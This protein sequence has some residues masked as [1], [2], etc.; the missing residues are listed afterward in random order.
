MFGNST[1]S[2]N[3]VDDIYASQAD[4]GNNAFQNPVNPANMNPG[5]GIDP[6]LLSPSYSANYRPQYSG[7]N[8]YNSYGHVGFFKGLSNLSPTSDDPNWGNPFM[9]QRQSI[10]DV[11]NR[12]ADAA[13]WGIQRI[14][15]PALAF[16]G[17]RYATKALGLGWGAGSRFGAGLGGGMAQ[18]FGFKPA[19]TGGLRA[20]ASAVSAAFSEGGIGAGLSTLRGVGF[21]GAMNLAARGGMG[22]AMGAAASLAMPLVI[23]QGG[24]YAAE[25]TLFDP[26]INTRKG[27]ENLR[28]NFDGISFSDST[29]NAITGKGL[30][31]KEST[32]M[33]QDLTHQGIDDM[34]FSTGEYRQGADMISRSGLLDSTNSKGLSKA[35]K[36]SMEQIKLIMNIA[37]M[38][39]LKDAIEELAKL[40]MAGASI[41]GGVASN[42]SNTMRTLGGLAAAAGTTVSKLMNTV[43]A[44][45][46]YLYQANGMTPYLGQMAA[47]GSYSAFA[48]GKRTGIIST[49][50]IARMGGLEGATQAS[51]TGQ[52]NA[53][54]TLFNQMA[55]YNS[56]IKGKKG[57]SGAG[58]Q[59]DL[60]QVTGEFGRSI[61]N[62]PLGTYGGLMLHG[63]QM[64]GK[65]MEERGS[66]AVQDQ[67]MPIA[68]QLGLIDKKTGKI[69]AERATPI[70]M[71]MGM[72]KDQIQ[73]YYEQ[74][75][76]ESDPETLKQRRKGLAANYKEQSAQYISQNG[77]YGGPIGSSVYDVRKA[78]RQVTNAVSDNV[79][80]PVTSAVGKFG[81]WVQETVHEVTYNNTL[82]TEDTNAEKY[83]GIKDSNKSDKVAYA[84]T[85]KSLSLFE[86]KTNSVNSDN[87]EVT[88]KLNEL[89]KA[90][91]PKVVEYF[92]T[93]DT[94]KRSALIKNL[95]N[96]GVLGESIKK[97]YSA[98]TP[99]FETPEFL[100][101]ATELAT[102]GNAQ[103]KEFVTEKNVAKKAELG[104]ILVQSGALGQAITDKYSPTKLSSPETS[105][106]VIAK[107]KELAKAGN[108][109]AIEFDTTTDQ[110]KRS[111]LVKD[112][113]KN[114]L[115]DDL[116]QKYN[117]YAGEGRTA[118]DVSAKFVGLDKYL[119][120]SKK[121]E[122]P[123][124]AAPLQVYAV[125]YADRHNIIITPEGKNK[126]TYSSVAQDL[127]K[128][129][130]EG[131][132]K[133]VEY[134]SEKDSKKREV[135]LRDM[136]KDGTI[137]PDIKKALSAGEPLEAISRMEELN[138]YLS[139]LKKV[140]V[141]KP[142][143]DKGWFTQ[144]VKN[145]VI[146]S[147]KMEPKVEQSQLT[148]ELKTVVG[149]DGLDT[150]KL[151]VL[152]L[153]NKVV[154]E[155]ETG[156][157]TSE[158]SKE[159]I[160]K[161][162]VVAE[163]MKTMGTKDSVE[164]LKQAGTMFKKGASLGLNSLAAS[165]SNKA[166]NWFSQEN[167]SKYDDA[168]KRGDTE[169]ADKLK[170][171]DSATKL[172]GVKFGQLKNAA[173]LTQHEVFGAEEL[174]KQYEKDDNK[175]LDLVNSNRID[176]STWKNAQAAIDM[177]RAV[178]E[179]G[180]H[181]DKMGK[182][183]DDKPVE[184]R[185]P[186]QTN[187]DKMKKWFGGSDNTKSIDKFPG[188]KR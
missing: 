159:E 161:N 45:G 8:S 19:T 116:K 128:L 158:N 117:P 60:L 163:Y 179:F 27:A 124:E 85:P 92:Q 48:A 15:A 9:H 51:L 181:V 24:M 101:K 64:A 88:T 81:D 4:T 72:D 54:Q 80:T 13:V 38:P 6:N 67:L 84:F 57:N 71:N 59:A 52:I 178:K 29:G 107:V 89:A 23:G 28:D 175:L 62:D 142:K 93:K 42:A 25:K 157:I 82:K 3:P 46:Q 12:P 5:W 176:T 70:L 33:A 43:G 36:E 133:A 112:L 150:S 47:A 136:V 87:A 140:D 22:L 132:P 174:R 183:V 154:T 76:A 56:Y 30:G 168:V 41:K 106:E 162:P 166:D 180:E 96:T 79:V 137:N 11:T 145:G 26:Y 135:L 74:V 148:K 177:G 125:P 40:Q 149:G 77:L 1:I 18:G 58:P 7:P 68:K 61:A 173:N 110:A 171:L 53:S 182:Q 152:D 95:I 155:M 37:K 160:A 127:T 14:V 114:S 185:E 188:N 73:A 184:G 44:Q 139:D 129:A 153:A 94:G 66:L 105:P 32:K 35:I 118:D 91:N 20:T 49:E 115:G 21:G 65:Q 122:A 86:T 17:A 111:V 167:K 170:V 156:K 102:K 130:T 98:E 121:V 109:K 164:A 146:T 120:T 69:S 134:F 104:K 99:T 100:N 187:F 39:E 31:Y 126:R 186:N 169:A 55:L 165:V 143:E 113:L 78:G 141:E 144:T 119:E 151:K 16:A 63:R 131:N 123:K 75:S 50:Q 147:T 108:Q 83:I 10:E 97:K 34:T 172:G 90:G 138:T 2:S 103:A